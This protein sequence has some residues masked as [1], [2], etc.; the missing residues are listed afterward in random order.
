MSGSEALRIARICLAL[1]CAAGMALCQEPSAPPAPTPQPAPA[2][3]TPQPQATESAPAPTPA[4]QPAPAPAVPI[5][6]V[7]V[8]PLAPPDLTS[9]YACPRDAAR[10]RFQATLAD[11]AANRSV[12]DAI[13]GFGQAFMEDRTYAAAA[14][15][16]GILAAIAEKWDDALAELEEAARLDPA[17]LA[18]IA[19][20]QIERLHLIASLEKTPDGRRKRSYD[21]ALLAVLEKLP[22][23]PPAEAMTALADVGRI[24]PKRWEAPALLAGLNG[25]GHGYDVA[26]KFLQIAIENAPGPAIRASLDAALKATERELRYVSARAGADAEA[27]RGEYSKAAELYEAAW[28]AIPARSGSGLDAAST[29]LL[30]DDTARAS[31][32]LA[33]LRQGLDGPAADRAAA[34]LKEL[35]PIEP[36]AKAPAADAAQFYRDPG[37]A[38][39]VRIAA[40]IP[41]IDPRPLEIYTRPLP[42]LVEDPEPVV[43]LA[44][45]TADPAASA[46]AVTLPSL[47]AP[48]IAGDHPWREASQTSATPGS[49]AGAQSARPVWS[50]D[51]VGTTRTPHSVSLTSEPAGAKVFIGTATD[52][53]CATPCNISIAAGT[54]PMR[55]TFPGYRD[56]ERSVRVVSRTQD[57]NV[58]LSAIR[59]SVIV[60]TPTPAALRINGTPV[61]AQSPA[62]L[63]LVPG[64][65][66]IGADFGP[67]TRERLLTVR[68]SARL[69]IEL[70][71]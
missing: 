45:L 29:L 5:V 12:P 70:R 25:D 52:S 15:N 30:N 66:R 51:L 2:E 6:T 42:K 58:Q 65:Y 55:L 47:P 33:R 69:R 53:V 24:D 38:E 71:P 20:P 27:A 31:A 34:M 1:V 9:P 36:A 60:E 68:P 16:L 23:M 43:L 40:L 39:P 13:R 19:A 17:G 41:P 3:P 26:A 67:V 54:Y 18:P 8:P 56:E 57:L 35:E 64:L 37:S 62:E 44:S 21:E 50:V 61:A 11:L 10:H 32:L 28:T 59:G 46:L 48:A 63:S 14:F 49:D 22:K 7:A 4:P